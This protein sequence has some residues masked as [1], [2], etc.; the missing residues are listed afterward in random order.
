MWLTTGAVLGLLAVGLGA[1]GAHGLRERLTPD[2]LAIYETG[3]RYQMF[4]AL[5]MVAV[6][7]LAHRRRLPGLGGAA[8]FFFLLGVIIFS[9][10]LYA[11]SLTGVSRWGA[12]TPIGG[13]C[14]MIGWALLAWTGLRL[15]NRG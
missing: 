1:F 2:M 10:S 14:L 6:A 12:V 3:A 7:S 5:A 13:V 11:L 8:N 4:H 15:R 9:G